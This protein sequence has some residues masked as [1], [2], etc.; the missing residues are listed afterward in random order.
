MTEC[1]PGCGL[2]C[3][4]VTLG[5]RLTDMQAQEHPSAAFAREHW[6]LIRTRPSAY[7]GGEEV[8]EVRC[9][10]F[11]P[12]TRLCTARE[13]RP[14]ICSRFPWYDKTPDQE[15]ELPGGCSFNADVHTLTPITPAG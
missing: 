2:C 9:D 6:T 14:P 15:R 3:D 4:P 8:D 12:A 5:F 1:L 7:L 10:A 11:D 13:Q